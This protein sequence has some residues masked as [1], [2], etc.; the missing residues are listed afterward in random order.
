MINVP[1]LFFFRWLTE[2]VNQLALCYEVRWGDGSLKSYWG[3]VM[4][5]KWSHI[6]E[7]CWK[8]IIF[9]IL[10][11]V[12]MKSGFQN[13]LVTRLYFKS[14]F[15][16]VFCCYFRNFRNYNS[17]NYKYKFLYLD[18]D[19]SNYSLSCHFILVKILSTN[20]NSNK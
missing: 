1:I 17:T 4:G 10:L 18:T 2:K 14:A 5:Y 8:Y 6:Y 16:V 11:I 20:G 13:F 3:K 7:I 19:W 12:I 15:I 9:Y